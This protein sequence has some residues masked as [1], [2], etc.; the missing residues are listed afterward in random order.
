MSAP[1]DYTALLKDLVWFNRDPQRT[2]ARWAQQ[3]Y[4]S[5]SNEHEREAEIND[6]LCQCITP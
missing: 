4:R 1:L 3:F 6:A 2:K 5:G